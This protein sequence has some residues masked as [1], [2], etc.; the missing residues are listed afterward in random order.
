MFILYLPQKK[1]L[2][3][4]NIFPKTDYHTI[5]LI[6]LYERTFWLVIY[7][8]RLRLILHNIEIERENSL[9][10]MAHLRSC[11]VSCVPR[12]GDGQQTAKQID[13]ASSNC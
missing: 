2:P 5:H 11:F 1:I 6:K 10:F 7:I 3:Q 12:S 9:L 13:L 8:G 4:S